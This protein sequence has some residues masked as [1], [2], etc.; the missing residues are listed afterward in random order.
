VIS[1]VLPLASTVV[2]PGVPATARMIAAMMTGGKGIRPSRRY[3]ATRWP[4]FAS[5]RLP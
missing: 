5:G 2:L 4:Q 1:V 3:A